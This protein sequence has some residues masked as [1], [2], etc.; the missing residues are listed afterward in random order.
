MS[1]LF[2]KFDFVKYLFKY[3]LSSTLAILFLLLSVGVSYSTFICSKTE[4]QKCCCVSEKIT[5]CTIDVPV[6]CCYEEI[7]VIQFDFETPIIKVQDVPKC[8]TFFT[9]KLNYQ[10]IN[11]NL[12]QKNSWAND[13][14]PPKKNSS[15]LS[16]LQSYLL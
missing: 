15:K 4:N 11:F 10:S 9:S 6:N 12:I 16:I 7:L 14:P 1:L 3:L 2:C 5:C 8:L 13:L